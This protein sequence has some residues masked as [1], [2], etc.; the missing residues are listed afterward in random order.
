MATNN[1][2]PFATGAGAN[3]TSQADYEA[4]SALL[5]GFQAGKASSAQINKALRQGSTMAS[6]L[7]QFISSA[8]MDA[9]DNGNAAVLLNNFLSALTTNL[10]LGNA[11]KRN[12]GTGLNQLPDMSFFPSSN[13][14]YGYF[15]LPN[16][17]IFQWRTLTIG[18]A[19]SPNMRTS[20][21]G[22]AINFPNAVFG[23]V[24]SLANVVSYFTDKQGFVSSATTTSGFTIGSGYTSSNATIT[25][26]AIGN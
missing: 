23:S 17:I 24:C 16:G 5:T 14:D 13:A 2:K 22:W 20:S 21:A 25:I 10:S 15:K 1:F 7:G 19:I 8:G 12:V 11:S 26:F 6:M 18:P 9:I 3:V 4:L